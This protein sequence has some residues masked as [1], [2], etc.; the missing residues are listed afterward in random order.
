[1]VQPSL[2]HRLRLR[3]H[4][5]KSSAEDALAE[6]STTLASLALAAETAANESKAAGE[7]RDDQ[8]VVF[9]NASNAVQNA[10]TELAARE[11]T[12]DVATSDTVAQQSGL[13]VSIRR[14]R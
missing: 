6:A 13:T 14:S 5:A 3:P 10:E 7:A 8:Q 1:M 11:A 12:L 2:T 9:D 4:A